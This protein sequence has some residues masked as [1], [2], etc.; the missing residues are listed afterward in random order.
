MPE[1]R[2]C[3]L[4]NSTALFSIGIDRHGAKSVTANLTEPGGGR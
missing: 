1:A 2:T 3:H 4:P